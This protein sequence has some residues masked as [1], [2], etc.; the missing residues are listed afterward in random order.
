MIDGRGTTSVEADAAPAGSLGRVVDAIAIAFAVF[1]LYTGFFG[2]LSGLHQRIVHLAFALALVY[3]TS[4]RRREGNIWLF[5][6]DMALAA[7]SLGVMGYAYVEAPLAMGVRAGIVLPADT[8]L[9][10][11]TL[12]LLLEA[13]RRLMGLGLPVICLLFLAYAFFGNNLPGMFGHRAYDLERVVQQLFLSNEGFFGLP[14]GISANYIVLFVLFGAILKSTSAGKFFIDLSYGLFGWSRGGPAKMAV[15][16]SALF[17]SISGSTVANTVATGA[18]TIPLMKKVGLKPVDA[19]AI[20]A[21]ASCGGQLMPPV[22]GAASF[23]IA[24]ILGIP[25]IEVLKGALIPAMLYFF[26]IFLMVDFESG[27]RGIA[28]IAR[29]ELPKVGKTLRGNWHLIVSPIVLVYLLGVEQHS[30][31]FSVT[32]AILAAVL[33]GMAR[34]HTRPSWRMLLE[35]LEEGAMS[36]V[37]IAIACATA[38]IV[39]GVF[40]LTGL[41]FKASSLLI[42]LAGGNLMMLLI[43]AMISSLILGT[44][45]PTVPAYLLLAV[46]VAPA[47]IDLGVNPLSAHLFIFYFGVISSITPPLA[48]AAYAGAS[49]AKCNPIETAVRAT[50]I[51]IVAY[52]I[53][54][55]FVYKPHLLMS[56]TA[57][58]VGLGLIES[59]VAV[60]GFVAAVQG[61]LFRP[62]GGR[63]RLVLLAGS[64]VT[65]IPGVTATAIGAV[66]VVG[67]A[68]WLKLSGSAAP[69]VTLDDR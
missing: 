65:V 6:L 54:Y 15:G 32:W 30:P 31:L 24:E 1:H 46:L 42:E 50:R 3:L 9:G 62:L 41:G 26:S 53:P 22:M 4:A 17:G 47:L 21:V 61:Y 57:S 18:F 33:V 64:I 23:L 59:V 56:G 27:R 19:A 29:S 5:A 25:Y 35:A 28:G 20:E 10:T 63:H 44:G 48:L 12:V 7:I 69:S 40:S 36:G 34:R 43:L 49:I 60:T 8:V 39:I 2:L 11:M 55:L 38:G 16:A 45:L 68:Y 51:G 14:L 58:Q 67:C 37:T 13:A 52:I 66:I